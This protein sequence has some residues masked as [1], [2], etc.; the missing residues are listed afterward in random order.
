MLKL[1]KMIDSKLVFIDYGIN[2][3]QESYCRQGYTIGGKEDKGGVA[4]KDPDV[5][6]I[7]H[8]HRMGFNLRGKI[9]NLICKL[10]PERF[11]NY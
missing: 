3:L 11:L 10:I 5:N 8:I 6:T 1:Y 9:N 4:H 2:R 7:Y